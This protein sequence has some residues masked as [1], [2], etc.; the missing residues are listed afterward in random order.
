[1]TRPEATQ[2]PNPRE[3]LRDTLLAQNPSG[4]ITQAA[5]TAAATGAADNAILGLPLYAGEPLV[6]FT[7][8]TTMTRAEAQQR[9]SAEELAA[10]EARVGTKQ[11]SQGVADN[12]SNT[13]QQPITDVA[14]G[15]SGLEPANDA[16]SAG[17]PVTQSSDTTSDSNNAAT[18]AP[19]MRGNIPAGTQSRALRLCWKWLSSLY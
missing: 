11:P 1:M 4:A 3:K 8:G 13:T 7:D 5:A 12:V 9:Y 16:G 14:T 6:N 17:N 15:T 18:P 19:S 2:Q 10:F